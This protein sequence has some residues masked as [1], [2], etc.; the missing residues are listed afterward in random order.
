MKYFSEDGLSLSYPD[1]WKSEREAT[2]EGWTVTL[3]SPGTAFAMIRLERDMPT[4]EAVALTA[5]EAL[6]EDYPSLE[7]ES[8]IDMLAGEMAIG[9]DIQF[10]TLDLVTTCWTRSF[11]GAAGTV[12]VLCQVSDVEQEAYEPALRAICA[13]MRTEVE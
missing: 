11:Y 1:D 6:K 3:Q 13:S 12:L 9:H 5:L 2:A 10:F 7:A 8:A 4:T